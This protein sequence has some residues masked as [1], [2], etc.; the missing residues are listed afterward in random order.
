MSERS[1]IENIGT[2]FV[3]AGTDIRDKKISDTESL[4]IM[5]ATMQAG[6]SPEETSTI[7]S[8]LIRDIEKAVK[9]M[10]KNGKI[11]PKLQPF[12][13]KDMKFDSILEF[14]D[15]LERKKIDY[16]NVFQD[17]SIRGARLITQRRDKIQEFMTQKIGS[18][19]PGMP[20]RSEGAVQEKY[21]A[22]KNTF[23]L[24]F[25]EL[26]GSLENLGNALAEAGN[27]GRFD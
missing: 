22:R 24:K 2:A 23:S 18:S 20:D 7:F 8:A 21:D 16:R 1:N 13:G 15:E 9:S 14:V 5:G 12:L 19:A 6:F 17:E 10:T 25:K 27:Y 3:K 11:S 26:I 4:A